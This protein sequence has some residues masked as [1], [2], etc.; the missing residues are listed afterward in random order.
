MTMICRKCK[1][2]IP[3]GSPYC[4]WCGQSQAV[5]KR[6][7]KSRGNGTGTV[8]PHNGKWIAEHTIFYLDAEGRKR[9]R[10]KSRT[11]VKRSDALL[12]LGTFGVD[13]VKPK[14]MTLAELWHE[15][16][17]GREYDALSKSQRDK[18]GYAWERWSAL[19]HRSI[20]SLTVADIEDHIENKTSS[21]YPARD[22]K[23]CLSHLY[24]IAL[25]KEIVSMRKTDY[26]DLPYDQPKAKRECWT[27]E[28]VDAL[29]ADL[30]SHPFTGYILIM[31]YAGLRYGELSTI[32]AEN[33]DLDNSVMIWGIK[34]D[35]GIDREIPIHPRIM[36]IIRDM[37]S[38]H[39]EKLLTIPENDFYARY[40]A[41]V[42][43]LG[44]RHLPPH[45]CR[46]YFFS[47]LTA[48]GVQGGIIAEVGGHASYLTTLKNYVRIPLQ[49]KLAA[50]KQI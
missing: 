42:D 28:E 5:K 38:S 13:E 23:V 43:R 39:P 11:F 30:P 31:C 16:A 14:D 37:L 48:A 10:T 18:L 4:N 32:P 3:E 50:V 44:L 7:T 2:E 45:T 8:Y 47:R 9:K 29:W 15:Y 12:S 20:S 49:D 1:K 27:Q 19:S 34:S 46:H 21:F 26:A 6:R 17:H 22:M 40:W 33:I 24:D 36:P 25:K 41:T 35:A